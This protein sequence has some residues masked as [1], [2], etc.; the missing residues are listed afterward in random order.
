M[1]IRRIIFPAIALGAVLLL[2]GC[3]HKLVATEGQTQVPVYPDE[4]TYKKLSQMKAQGGVAGML[5]G[6]GES[7]A[8]GKVDNKTPV[9][10]ISS[11]DLGAQI[12]VTD[13]PNKG[14]KGF[15]A[16]ANVD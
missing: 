10:I 1:Q 12:E 8:S 3:S 9:N 16:K 7:L 6:M 2:A 11:D 4:D 15:A 5:G 13:G 14:L